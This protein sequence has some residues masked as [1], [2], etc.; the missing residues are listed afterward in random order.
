MH[1]SAP[2]PGRIGIQCT[3]E[4]TTTGRSLTSAK[5]LGEG[6]RQIS[7][8]SLGSRL[9]S[10]LGTFDGASPFLGELLGS[11]LGLRRLGLEGAELPVGLDGFLDECG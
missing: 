4:T 3:P 9:E 5:P 2:P 1:R 6:P 10:T 7:V 8:G 11:D